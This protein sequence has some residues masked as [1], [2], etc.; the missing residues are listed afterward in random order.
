MVVRSSSVT[1]I[2]LI[3]A[4]AAGCGSTPT[5]TPAPTLTATPILTPAPTV[6]AT[7]APT[8]A[9]AEPTQAPTI[10]PTPDATAGPHPEGRIA[11]GREVEYDPLFGQIVALYAV[12]P[13]GSNLVQLTDGDSAF[14]AWSPDGTRLAFAL[15]M[16]DGSWQIATIARDG[17]DLQV[18]T[19]GPGIH[20]VPSW[21]PDGSWLA[22][23]YSALMPD[24][25]AFHTVIYRMDADGSN[26]EL[27]GN[28]D[29]FDVEAR[30]SPDGTRVVFARLTFEGDDMQA[31]LFVRDIESGEEQ[32]L[33]AA[34][35]ALKQPNWSPDGEWIIY[36]DL[37]S[38]TLSRVRADG[39]GDPVVIYQAPGNHAAFKPWYSP[40]GSRIVFGCGPEGDDALCLIDAD[41]SNL[42]V[43]IDEPGVHENHFSWGVT[44][45]P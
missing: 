26:P 23:G 8:P 1:L 24:D 34:G 18:L 29:T 7:P 11:F 14:P 22:Y 30:V 10:A 39:T 41:G 33:A 25:D 4:V 27:L 15:R 32:A 6:M 28:P 36:N 40:D 45:S 21:S 13:D 16:D 5:S 31:S 2:L 43:L 20:E 17:T 37:E 44:P 42:E 3:A 19:S 9:T 38:T 12:D 35:N